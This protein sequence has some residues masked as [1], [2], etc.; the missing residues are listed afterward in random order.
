MTRVLC[1]FGTRPEIIKLSRVIAELDGTARLPAIEAKPVTATPACGSNL[2][3][4][5]GHAG[6]K[7]AR[8][9]AAAGGHNLLMI[10]PPGSGQSML[11]SRLAALLPELDDDELLDE[12]ED[13]PD[14]GRARGTDSACRAD[15]GGGAAG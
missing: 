15:T 4:V 3:D 7:R 2:D 9:V 8:A 5:R 11:A 14:G 12:L 6:A 13:A 1:L 10:G